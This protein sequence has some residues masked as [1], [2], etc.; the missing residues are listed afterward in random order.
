MYTFIFIKIFLITLKIATTKKNKNEFCH[1]HTCC[2]NETG[3]RK[4]L[5]F[6]QP[7]LQRVLIRAFSADSVTHTKSNTTKIVSRRGEN[8]EIERYTRELFPKSEIVL[9]KNVLFVIVLFSGNTTQV[10]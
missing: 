6:Y 2:C 7:R 10:F 4:Q 3:I 9:T 1:S 5:I 8:Q